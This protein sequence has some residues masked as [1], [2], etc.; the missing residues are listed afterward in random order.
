MNNNDIKKILD[1][2]SIKQNLIL[3]ALF[4][5][6]YEN[7]KYTIID[8]VKNFFINDFENEQKNHDIYKKEVLRKAKKSRNN[9]VNATLLWFK[10]C[11]AISDIDIFNFEKITNLR[12]ELT[13]QMAD[14]IV[15]NSL[16]KDFFFWYETMINL[17]KKIDKWWLNEIEIPIQ[18]EHMDDDYDHNKVQSLNILFLEIIEAIALNKDYKHLEKYFKLLFN[19][20]LRDSLKNI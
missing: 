5:A 12:N 13:H 8:R 10:E 17:F 19:N 11:N 9:K 6:I 16:P 2:D 1:P 20:K 18:M 4:I 3:I 15:H 7:F 14:Y